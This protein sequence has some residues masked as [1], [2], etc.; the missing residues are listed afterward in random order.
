MKRTPLSALRFPLI[1]S[2]LAGL[3]AAPVWAATVNPI[4]GGDP[5]EGLDLEGN[6]LYAITVGGAAGAG[7]VGD[8]NFTG[9]SVAGVNVEATDVIPTWG[10]LDFG[11]TLNDNNLE[12]VL[13]SIR[14]M[15]SSGSPPQP[16]RV[17]F[18]GLEPG[19]Q[20]KLQLLFREQCCARAFDVF[21]DG[22]LIFDDFNPGNEQGGIEAHPYAGAVITHEFTAQSATL[23]I[24]LDGTDVSP[25]YPDHNPILSGVTIERLS[26]VG[27]TDLDGLP[28]DWELKFFGSL[29]T[30][31]DDDPDLDG[32]TNVNEHAL[33]TFPND[34]DSDKDGLSDGAEVNTHHSDPTQADTD[35]DR[36]SDGAEVNTYN[37]DPV[38]EDTDGDGSSDYAEICLMTNPLDK[39]SFS[40]T[41]QIGLFTGADPG[42]G[43]DMDGNFLY[44]V[45]AA[46]ND[47]AGPVRDAYF[48][49]DTVEGV[50]LVSGNVAAGWHTAVK[51]GDSWDDLVLALVMS[52]IRWSDATSPT[53][54]TVTLTFSKLE[55]G[56]AYKL[57]L[58]FA[59]EGWPRGFDVYINGRLVVNDFAPFIWQG[60]YPKDN[61]VVITH[62]FLSPGTDATIVLDGRAVSDPR[63]TDH[64]AILQGATLELVAANVDSDG[65]TLPDPWEIEQFGNLGQVASSDPDHD[66]LDN[67]TEFKL[68]T[69][70][71]NPDTDGDALPDGAEV[72]LHGTDPNRADT[73]GDGLADG[74]ELNLHGTDPKKADSD[75][76][77]LPDGREVLVHLTNPTRAD[78]DDD[79]WTDMAELRLLTDPT[80]KNNYPVN[81]TARTF[82]GGDP[83]EGLDLEGQFLYAVNVG[84]T[85]AP[86]QVRDANFIGDPGAGFVVLSQ[87]VAPGWRASQLGETAND[88]V[89]DMVM[90]SIRWSDVNHTPRPNIVVELR[91]L[92]P[93][94]LYKLQLLFGEVAW[95][96]AFDIAFNGVQIADDFAPYQFQGGFNIMNNGVVFTYEFVALD[97]TATV[98]LDG[99]TVTTPGLTDHNPILQGFTL[100]NIGPA[101]LAPVITSTAITPAGI[102]VT[103]GSVAGRAYVLLYKEKLDDASWQELPGPV[104]AT[105]P[106]TT[107]VD[108]S[109]AHLTPRQGFWRVMMK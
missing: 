54:P 13:L 82:T 104:T 15:V 85:E 18:H 39:N 108:T 77:F 91:N 63:M 94:T 16:M 22:V 64:N 4:Y 100:E 11:D 50:S 99:R 93:G 20:Y 95:P 81:P 107:I 66:G 41:T 80:N 32:L 67:A 8:A 103:F 70:P 25:D 47:P 59:E 78:T 10:T 51:L 96:H 62:T 61:G 23:L 89:L 58:L 88:M 69:N 2:L 102:A 56:A 5:G 97:A 19:A 17:T 40:K 106:T 49:E 26:A 9:D 53:T 38:K 65:D 33:G 27:D 35:G 6:F 36:L 101:P 92:A 72:D 1:E 52:S 46:N 76:D 57:Q 48:T 7:Q 60:G 71:A 109:P 90:S 83:G 74:A 3:L 73:D 105:G 75:G 86:G 84:S 68:N 14:H 42:E 31:R 30:G 12:K 34:H 45:N 44:A 24:A 28:D 21:V 43:L 98:V 37:T 79:G 87:N 55:A 29:N